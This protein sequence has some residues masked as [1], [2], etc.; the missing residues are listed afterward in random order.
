MALLL[1]RRAHCI[2][3]MSFADDENFRLHSY[4]SL[5]V[6][7]L[8]IYIFF[9]STFF[10]IDNRL[11]LRLFASVSISVSVC[12]F[13]IY[14][15]IILS[16]GESVVCARSSALTWSPRDFIAIKTDIVYA[17]ERARAHT[18]AL[19]LFLFLNRKWEERLRRAGKW[20]NK[21]AERKTPQCNETAWFVPMPTVVA[22]WHAECAAI[23]V[24]QTQSAR[25]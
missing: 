19:F 15:I 18:F 7:Y 14:Y 8:L 9:C 25:K 21:K 4:E 2:G 5:I 17:C 16:V 23:T 13:L 11:M 12:L 3:T 6:H 1:T 10:F 20:I 22:D 24:R